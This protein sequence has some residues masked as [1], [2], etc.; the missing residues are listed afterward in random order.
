MHLNLVA[1][2]STQLTNVKLFIEIWL[3]AEG[4]Q[5][6]SMQT[7]DMVFSRFLHTLLLSFAIILIK[8]KL[9]LLEEIS[10]IFICALS[11]IK[12]FTANKPTRKVLLNSD[13]RERFLINLSNTCPWSIQWCYTCHMSEEAA[14]VLISE[15]TEAAW[16]WSTAMK[17]GRREGS[18]ITEA[19]PQKKCS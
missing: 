7:W 8:T 14:S 2:I 9:F 11:P 12:Q 16:H 4:G 19:I 3:V 6:R 17:M 10:F 13:E 5:L 15:T 1:F 18:E